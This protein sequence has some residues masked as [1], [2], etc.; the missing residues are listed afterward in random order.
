MTGHARS[1]PKLRGQ[2]LP[3]HQAGRS[4]ARACSNALQTRHHHALTSFSDTPTKGAPGSLPWL[5]PL[6]RI[7]SFRDPP[8]LPRHSSLRSS[9]V[10]TICPSMLSSLKLVL[11]LHLLIKTSRLT[12]INA[13]VSAITVRCGLYT[14]YHSNY[15]ITPCRKSRCR[16]QMKT[17]R[18]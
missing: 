7:G 4:A 11:F 1:G 6:S 9:I 16:Y 17:T 18:K 3:V 5:S 8:F 14:R 13:Q 12:H 10:P 2:V 15:L